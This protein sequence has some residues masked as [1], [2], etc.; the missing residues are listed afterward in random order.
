MLTEN[1]PGAVPL[2]QNTDGLETMIP[3]EYQEKYYEICKQWEDLTKLQLEHDTYSKIILGDVNNYIAVHNYKEVSKE[4]LEEIKD[5]NPHY[6]FKQEDDKHYYAATKCK[7]RFEFHALALHKNKSFAVIPKA[8]Y[9]YFVK[10]I[11]PE[12]TLTKNTSIFDYCAGKKINGSWKFVQHFADKQI[13]PH[14]AKYTLEQKRDY[15]LANGWEMSWSKDNWVRSN[16]QNKEANTGI[17]TES[18]FQTAAPKLPGYYTTEDLQKTIRYYI[19][20]SGVKIIKYNYTDG[21]EIQVEAGKWLQKLFIKA[22]KQ[23]RFSDYDIDYDFYMS[24]IKSE[25]EKLQPV[26]D[27]LKL[28]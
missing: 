27:Q 14:Y 16:A 13:D 4:E 10:G 17:N 6:L 3:R 28:F 23:E 24:K 11:D 20:R 12:I 25:I 2:M 1:I 9:N 5:E 18:A 15:L 26:N 7:G 19:G 8:I 22:E 21:R